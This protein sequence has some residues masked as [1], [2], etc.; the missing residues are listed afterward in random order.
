MQTFIYVIE[1]SFCLFL[2]LK[3]LHRFSESIFNSQPIHHWEKSTDFDTRSNVCFFFHWSS[4]KFNSTWK[5]HDNFPFKKFFLTCVQ[6]D[7]IQY[8]NLPLDLMRRLRWKNGLVEIGETMSQWNFLLSQFFTSGL[9][10]TLFA[11]LLEDFPAF[12]IAFFFTFSIRFAFHWIFT[13][14]FFDNLY[15][16]FPSH[17][18]T[19]FEWFVLL[20]EFLSI[21]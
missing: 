13:S 15:S 12:S 19:V 2:S 14:M 8:F 6:P 3:K 1:A 20:F 21:L 7:F 4:T 17:S 9:N 16:I 11:L 10:F 18:R 5:D